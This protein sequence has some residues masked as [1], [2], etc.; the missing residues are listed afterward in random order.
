MK[1]RG[2]N[3]VGALLGCASTEPN[4]SR[5]SDMSRWIKW[6]VAALF[7]GGVA[8]GLGGYMLGWVAFTSP[9]AG[10]GGSKDRGPVP[11][12][13]QPITRGA[14]EQQRTFSGTLESPAAMTVAAKVGGRIEKLAVDFADTVTRGQV[15]A[16]LDSDEYQQQLLQA[17]AE[18]QVAEANLAEAQNGLEIARRA[19]QRV[20]TLRERGV[21]SEAQ[22]DTARADEL[23]REAAVQVAEAQIAR[24]EAA[25]KAA[26][27]RLGYTTVTAT[28]TGGDDQRVVAERFVEQGDTVN[29]N[30]PLFS[31]VELQPIQAVI[32]VTERDYGMLNK[33]QAVR[34]R[35]DA[36]PGQTFAGEV[37]RVAPVFR[38]TSRQARVEVT[39][40][41]PEGKLKPGMFIRA[42]TVLGQAEDAT[43]LPEAALAR[44][45][46]RDVVF[47]VDEAGRTVRQREVKVGIQN[48]GRIQVFGEGLQG[49]VVV[50]GQQQLNDGTPI[51]IPESDDVSEAAGP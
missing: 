39:V 38:E 32:H 28:W 31:I 7:V 1:R 10:G 4:H 45:D 18:L 26:S 46:D 23:S 25:V 16:E 47:V 51:V 6:I 8:L 43:I 14:I 17:E 30:T 50:L 35:T 2:D 22:L 41:N 37:A 19:M 36:Y 44:R 27:I 21:A 24:A 49:R 40:D 48:E 15:V 33:G 13:V 42:T 12:E 3:R 34:L 11:V 20:E 9:V 29:A 5:K